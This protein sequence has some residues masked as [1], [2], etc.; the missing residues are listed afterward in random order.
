MEHAS[1]IPSERTVTQTT[2]RAVTGQALLGGRTH[3]LPSLLGWRGDEGLWTTGTSYHAL[4]EAIV[5][6]FCL[7]LSLWH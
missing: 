2:E 5:V 4:V 1:L 7:L 3:R 6:N